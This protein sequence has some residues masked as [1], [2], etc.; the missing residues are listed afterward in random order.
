MIVVYLSRFLLIPVRLESG[1]Y[2]A[3]ASSRTTLISRTALMSNQ[4]VVFHAVGPG[5]AVGYLF[6]EY[7]S[8]HLNLNQKKE[9]KKQNER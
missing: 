5:C 8:L 9:C 6:C 7:L 3:G 2:I 1:T 4:R